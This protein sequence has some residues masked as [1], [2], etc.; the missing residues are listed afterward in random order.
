MENEFWG[1]AVGLLGLVIQAIIEGVQTWLKHKRDLELTE[2]DIRVM[3]AEIEMAPRNAGSSEGSG[4]GTGWDRAMEG[5]KLPPWIIGL[6]GTMRPVLAISVL[7]S[8][9]YGFTKLLGVDVPILAHET[10]LIELSGTMQ[11][12]TLMV[13]TFFFGSKVARR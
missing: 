12:L 1:A 5:S 7:W 3:Q 8:L 2:M 13:F 6:R 10:L 4:G 9:I 11:F